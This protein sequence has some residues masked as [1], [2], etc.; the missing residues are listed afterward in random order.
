[1][2]QPWRDRLDWT[3]ERSPDG[4]AIRKAMQ[5][6]INDLRKELRGVDRKIASANNRAY[7]L[8]AEAR[9]R[10]AYWR[11]AANRYQKELT[12]RINNAR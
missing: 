5:A 12:Q 4:A 10:A 1:M 2:I 7:K 9:Q 8:V 6:E 11:D 3:A